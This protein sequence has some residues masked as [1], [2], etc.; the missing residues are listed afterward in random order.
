[1]KSKA[2]YADTGHDGVFL[3]RTN[4]IEKYLKKYP[5]TVQLRDSC[6]IKVISENPVMNMG[7]SKETTLARVLIYPTNDMLKWVDDNSIQLKPRTKSKFY[8]ALTRARYSAAIVCK[9]SKI[10]SHDIQGLHKWMPE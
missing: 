6:K 10:F 7:E 4:D 3:V 8:V 5:E 2:D 9:D 1:M